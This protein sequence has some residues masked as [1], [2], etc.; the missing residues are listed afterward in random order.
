[1]PVEI[2]QTDVADAESLLEAL[3][4]EQVPSGRFSQGSALRDLTVKALAFTYAYFKKENNTVRALGSLLTVQQVAVTDAETDRNVNQAT[5]AILSNWF[6]NRNMGMFARGILFITVTKRQDYIIPGNFRFTYDRTRAFFPD[7]LDPTQNI[8]IRASDL[9]TVTNV[10]GIVEG[11][12]FTLRVVGSRTGVEHNIEPGTWQ[13]SASFTPYATRI[14]STVKFEGG[15]NRETTTE[16]VGRSNTAI[17][18]RNLINTRSIEATLRDRFNVPGKML[19]VGMGDPEMQRDRKL[20][21]ATGSALHVGGHFDVYV[22]LPR[23][24]ETFDGVIGGTFQ[25]PDGI[26]N[27]FRDSGITD[28]TQ[29]VVTAQNQYVTIVPGDVLRVTTGLA[30]APRDFVI[31]EV[32]PKELR[33]GINTPFSV[34]TDESNVDISYCIYRPLVGTD[35]QLLPATGARQTGRTSRAISIANGVALPGNAR[36]AILDVAVI[37]PDV[38]DLA[39]NLATGFVHFPYRTNSAPEQSEYQIVSK[40]P[41]LAQSMKASEELYVLGYEGK[42]LRVVYESL[43]GL[44]VLHSFTQDRF[45][46]VMAGNILVRGFIP[47]YL[48]MTVPYRLKSTAKTAID[49]LA[50]RQSIVD[51]VNTFNPHDIVDISDVSQTTR[52]FSDQIGSVLPFEITYTILTPDGRELE[53]KTA[54]EVKLTSDYTAGILT[55]PLS[56]GISDRTVRYFSSLSRVLVSQQS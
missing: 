30:E 48:T 39:I 9:L 41:H 32:L 1:M 51:M 22:E 4:T 12:Q 43:A 24:Q 16:L 50:L 29:P 54:D 20:E 17:T 37:N 56:L 36:L 53:F 40:Q 34:P 15:K 25:R 10:E 7:V 6:I 13:G 46:R 18:V 49:E 52:Q 27:V 26:C 47:V 35:N 31:K 45:E 55:D 21:F 11:Y 28:F 44:D 8:V 42:T 23:I 5:D 3:L 33:V 38:G 2:S 14:S 19:V